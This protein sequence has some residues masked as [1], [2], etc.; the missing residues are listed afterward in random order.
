MAVLVG[1]VLASLFGVMNR[2]QMMT[3]RH[4]RVVA[5]FFVVPALLVIG[6]RTMMFGR[7]IVVF[8]GFAVMIRNLF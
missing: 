7:V 6:G 1:V 8:G 3:V 4:M 2:V 5:G